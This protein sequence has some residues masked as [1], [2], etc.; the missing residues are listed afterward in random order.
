MGSLFLSD[1]YEADD[2]AGTLSWKY[3]E[4]MIV[5]LVSKDRDYLQLVDDAHDVRLWVPA[6]EKDAENARKAG[7][8]Y[9]GD[10]SMCPD[11]MKHFIEYTDGK[12]YA[13]KG[14]YPG[15]IPDLKA[16]EGIY[17][18]IDDCG[19]DAKKEKELAVFWK[20]ELSVSR[21]P[22]N[23]MKRDREM[24]FLSLDLATIRTY[25]GEVMEFD[26]EA[27]PVKCVDFRKLNEKMLSLGIRSAHFEE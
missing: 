20:T 4:S 6:S 2:L 22:I 9:M 18:A 1:V 11:F 13:D 19:G 10:D 14:V 25:C 17:E 24:A 21:N 16:I 7:S 15:N 3:K 23:A 26:L 27:D 8:L 5:R 12:V